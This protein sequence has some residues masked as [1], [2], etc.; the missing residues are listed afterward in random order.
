MNIY[1]NKLKR[2]D[3]LHI[4]SIKRIYIY[5]TVDNKIHKLKIS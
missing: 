1:N 2:K 3:I 5:I 4:K